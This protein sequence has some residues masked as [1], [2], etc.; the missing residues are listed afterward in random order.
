MIK[1]QMKSDLLKA[2]YL[3][4]F[5]N[6][7]TKTL[8]SFHLKSVKNFIEHLE[9]LNFVEQ[10]KVYNRISEYM[11]LVS[12]TQPQII[13]TRESLDLFN[14]YVYPLGKIYAKELDFGIKAT[15]VS[16]LNFFIMCAVLAA[17]KIIILD[18]IEPV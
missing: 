10:E 18:I 3:E 4:R 1:N 7:D 5:S 2:L 17:I 16:V 15:W 9:E 14:E 11:N 12:D 6:L 8:N 13:D